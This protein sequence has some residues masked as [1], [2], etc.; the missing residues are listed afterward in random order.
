VADA[1]TAPD[2]V[3]TATG[4]AFRFTYAGWPSPL[5]VR[6]PTAAQQLVRTMRGE[7]LKV[8]TPEPEL[9]ETSDA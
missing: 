6:N 8:R 9:L 3:V 7:G 4:G 1:W 2:V 5:E